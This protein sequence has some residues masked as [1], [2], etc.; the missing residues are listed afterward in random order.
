MIYT[1]VCLVRPDMVCLELYVL[2]H[3]DSITGCPMGTG[4]KRS[5]QTASFMY[6]YR[7]PMVLQNKSHCIQFE[8]LPS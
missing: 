4:G 3:Q 2:E 7:F 6:E 5:G 8:A 1:A